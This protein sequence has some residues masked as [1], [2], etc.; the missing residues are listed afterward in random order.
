MP[1]KPKIGEPL[2]K[3]LKKSPVQAYFHQ[4]KKAW[5]TKISKG[6]RA[7]KGEAKA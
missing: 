6:K 3:E 5:G 1:K 7:N 4:N 2:V